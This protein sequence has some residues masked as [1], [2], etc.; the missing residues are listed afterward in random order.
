[1]IYSEG[2]FPLLF[3][4]CLIT[5]NFGSVR[6]L[7]LQWDIIAPRGLSVFSE[8]ASGAASLP[9]AHFINLWTMI[10]EI[11]TINRRLALP[12]TYQIA[13]RAYYD[14]RDKLHDD[15]RSPEDLTVIL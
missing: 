1:M 5:L 3:F 15:H 9:R 6:D 2:V 11:P 7:R 4:V 14:R 10:R 13:P 8:L 12:R